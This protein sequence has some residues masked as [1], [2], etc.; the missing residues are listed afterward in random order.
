MIPR[1]GV[2]NSSSVSSL[3]KALT[4]L[5]VGGRKPSASLV[6]GLSTDLVSTLEVRTRPLIDP[7]QLAYDLEAVLNGHVITP[8]EVNMAMTSADAVLR[9]SGVPASRM[10]ALNSSM[11]QVALGNTGQARH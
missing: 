5:V 7:M 1:G 4:S 3:Q 2:A 6:H 11:R 9:A 10:Q 8:V